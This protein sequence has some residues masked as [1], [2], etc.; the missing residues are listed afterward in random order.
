MRT[1]N[2]SANASRAASPGRMALARPIHGPGPASLVHM[3]SAQ[4]TRPE[5]RTMRLFSATTSRY[6]AAS[7]AAFSVLGGMIWFL[8][9]S[10]ASMTYL[11]VWI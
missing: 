2:E 5:V 7:T 10:L 3:E 4:F 8:E 9:A 1:A 11:A 6:P